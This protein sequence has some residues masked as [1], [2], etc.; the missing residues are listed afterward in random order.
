MDTKMDSEEDDDDLD[1]DDLDHSHSYLYLWVVVVVVVESSPDHY[2]FHVPH[3]V[4]GYCGTIVATPFDRVVV[5]LASSVPAP[6]H[7]HYSYYCY[8]C[9]S[10]D[11]PED[12]EWNLIPWTVTRRSY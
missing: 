8:Y 2:S 3:F 9:D 12:G 6:H 4:V 1:D 5:V 7:H 11:A 10:D